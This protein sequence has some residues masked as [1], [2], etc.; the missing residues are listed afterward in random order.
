MTINEAQMITT[1]SLII[2]TFLL[3]IEVVGK[4]RVLKIESAIHNVSIGAEKVFA[5]VIVALVAPWKEIDAFQALEQPDNNKHDRRNPVELFNRSRWVGPA[6]LTL[7]FISLIIFR[8]TVD[9]YGEELVTI[10]CISSWLGMI[11]TSVILSSLIGAF[12][13]AL[14][15][16]HSLANKLKILIL[17]ATIA[18][19]GILLGVTTIVTFLS[20]WPAVIIF[21]SYVGIYFIATSLRHIID[22]RV[23]H[24]LGNIFILFGFVLSASGIILQHFISTGAFQ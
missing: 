22:F 23:R 7:A 2:G 16:Q 14:K 21:L 17:S 1:I 9:R 19:T 18:V 20:C 12:Q 11:L 3:A 4:E 10:V 24:N 13:C 15:E 5:S 8:F 6:F